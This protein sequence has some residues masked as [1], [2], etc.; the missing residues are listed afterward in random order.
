MSPFRRLRHA[1]LA[2][3]A[4]TALAAGAARAATPVRFVFDWATPDHELIPIVVADANGYYKQA[5]LDVSVILPPDSQTTG[6]LLVSG[7]GDIGFEGTTDVAFAVEQGIPIVA[8]A[9]FTQHNNWCL[10]GRPGE[11]VELD[12]LAGKSIAIYTD[13]WTKAMMPF[14]LRAAKLREDQVKL[15]IATDEDIPL[16]LAHKI[17]IAT[18]TS[19]Y[20]VAQ[21]QAAVH[22]DPTSLCAPAFGAPDVPVWV[23]TAAKPWLASHGDIARKWLSATREALIWSVAHPKEAVALFEKAYPAA[24]QHSYNLI[25]WETLMPE[26]RGKQGYFVQDGATWTALAEALKATGQISTVH[27]ADAYFTNAYLSP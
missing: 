26:M 15:V 19:N 25:G 2:C 27:P 9:A 7:R 4:A 1:A 24:A 22:K 5:G 20:A 14:V 6:R 3:L 12:H 18:N 17:D 11:P 23:Y 21:V 13:S 10:F 8:L 16:L